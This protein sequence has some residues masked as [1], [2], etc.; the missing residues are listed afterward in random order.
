[1]RTFLLQNGILSD[2][3]WDLWDGSIDEIAISQVP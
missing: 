2:A 3:L 1:M